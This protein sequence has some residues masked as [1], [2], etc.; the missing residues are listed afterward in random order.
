MSLQMVCQPRLRP[1]AWHQK[2]D[3]TEELTTPHQLEEN[4]M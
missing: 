2:Q 4:V 1:P 3:N